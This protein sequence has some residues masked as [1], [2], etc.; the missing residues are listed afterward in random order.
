MQKI[1]VKELVDFTRKP[2]DKGKR[3][4]AHKLKHRV[5]KKK[6]EDAGNEGGEITGSRVLVV[7]TTLLSMTKLI[8]MIVSWMISRLN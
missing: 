5:L 7:F 1:T 8:F 2:T 4:F 6:A 3:S